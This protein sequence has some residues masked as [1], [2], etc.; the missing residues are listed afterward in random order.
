MTHQI[1]LPPDICK[2][3]RSRLQ[4]NEICK[5]NRAEAHR[6]ALRSDMIR[7]QFTVKYHTA[8]I[9]PEAVDNEEYV[10]CSDGDSKTGLVGT[11]FGIRCDHSCFDAQH[12]ATS[13][14]TEEHE[15]F[16]ADPVHE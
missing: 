14:D 11:S 3:L 2:R 10:E 4:V 12:S 6:R 7:E 16:S 9:N 8:D 13:S 15:R 5:G 1:E